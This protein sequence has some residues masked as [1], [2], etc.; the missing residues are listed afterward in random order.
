MYTFN[1]YELKNHKIQETS[2]KKKS[3]HG[4]GHGGGGHGGGGHGH[5][6]DDA[7]VKLSDEEKAQIKG[8][9]QNIKNADGSFI[10]KCYINTD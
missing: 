1:E 8:R 10:Y 5:G 4:H 2:K 9:Y 3:G 6:H 7:H